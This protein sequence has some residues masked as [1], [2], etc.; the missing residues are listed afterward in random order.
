MFTKFGRGRLNSDGD[1]GSLCG[2][3]E[4]FAISDIIARYIS[5]T[6]QDSPIITANDY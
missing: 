1:R 3:W 2:G 6:V 4:N 5:V